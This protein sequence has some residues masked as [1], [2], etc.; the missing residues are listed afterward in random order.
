MERLPSLETFR[1]YQCQSPMPKKN[2]LKTILC[3]LE[4]FTVMFPLD[5]IFTSSLLSSA[6][7]LCQAVKQLLCLYTEGILFLFRVC[8]KEWNQELTRSQGMFMGQP[9]FI[10]QT[11]LRCKSWGSSRSWSSRNPQHCRAVRWGAGYSPQHRNGLQKR[12]NTDPQSKVL[13]REIRREKYR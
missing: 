2:P 10:L 11:S 8:V 12:T 13:M 5:K 1:Q 3:L 4:E 9:K 6:A 7:L